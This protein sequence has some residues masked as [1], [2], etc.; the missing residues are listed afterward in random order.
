LYT[1]VFEFVNRHGARRD[2]RPSDRRDPLRAHGAGGATFALLRYGDPTA[3]SS[4]E[5]ILGI[6]TD[7]AGVVARLRTPAIHRPARRHAEHGVSVAFVADTEGHLI[8]V[9][10]LLGPDARQDEAA[11]CLR[12]CGRAR[13][14]RG[15]PDVP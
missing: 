4:D 7:L 10:E 12:P 2:R 5:V 11:E 8:E 15:G 14:V 3:P 13:S 6:V 9:V 1:S